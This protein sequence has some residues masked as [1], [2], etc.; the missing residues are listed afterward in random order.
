M[1]V[2]NQI[3]RYHL[4]IEALRRSRRPVALADK[5]SG[6]CRAK[7]EQHRAYIREHM[8]DMPEI[9]DWKWSAG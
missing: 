6:E 7:L 3:S 8:Q 2:L 4:C 5:L 9:R 1:V